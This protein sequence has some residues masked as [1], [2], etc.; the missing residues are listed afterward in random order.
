MMSG[1]ANALGKDAEVSAY[2]HTYKI[3][4]YTH[5]YMT[6]PTGLYTTFFRAT[7]KKD[8]L[9]SFDCVGRGSVMYPSG[10]VAICTTDKV[11]PRPQCA[12][13]TLDR[14]CVGCV[15]ACAEG[16]RLRNAT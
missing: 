11:A 16:T 1:R 10:K 9:G 3:H 8:V 15:A 6:E 4:T 13:G 12:Q 14:D 5:T 2:K 7:G